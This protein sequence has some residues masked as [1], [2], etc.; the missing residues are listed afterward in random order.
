MILLLITIIP[1]ISQKDNGV[2]LLLI[3][4]MPQIIHKELIFLVFLVNTSQE[5]SVDT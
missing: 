1:Q 3:T 2:T 4:I 5:S